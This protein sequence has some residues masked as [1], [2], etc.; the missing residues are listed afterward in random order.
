MFKKV[1]IVG[2]GLIGGSLGL[3]IKKSRLAD[4]VIGIGHR[5]SSLKEALKKRAVDRVTLD[6]KN[7]VKGANLIIVATPVGIMP[8]IVNKIKKLLKGG[9]IIIDVGSTKKEIGSKIE[10][11]LSR[12]VHYVGCHPMAGS[13]KRGV[14]FADKEL[15]KNSICIITPTK[16]TDGQA[17][18]KVKVFWKRLGADV[19]ILAPELHDRLIGE[20]SHIPHLAATALV[21]VASDEAMKYAS[22]GFKDVT[23]I[24][25]SEPPL[26]RDICMTNRKYIASALNRYISVLKKIRAKIELGTAQELEKL[27]RQ[28]KAKRDR[29]VN[30]D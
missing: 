6:L 5:K 15:F 7:G 27:F 19:R 8:R 12:G 30:A 25:S 1:A 22:G 23:R 18:N 24:A 14:G 17:L 20:I 21:A 28:A 29:L 3:A 11:A 2:V 26:W 13:E 9:A 10:N 4:E 16:R